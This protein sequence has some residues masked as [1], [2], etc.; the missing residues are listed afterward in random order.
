MKG[1]INPFS[2]DKQY[3]TD[4][5]LCF[6]LSKIEEAYSQDLYNRNQYSLI[7]LCIF[8]IL[9]LIFSYFSNSC[10]VSASECTHQSLLILN[11]LTIF[12]T[13]FLILR[14]KSLTPWIFL[15]N[16]L[17]P[18]MKIMEEF[19][20][21]VPFILI[22]GH[23]TILAYFLIYSWRK[24]LI[25]EFSGYFMIYIYLRFHDYFLIEVLFK[26]LGFIS[27]TILIS[28]FLLF[29]NEKVSK[30]KWVLYD[31]FKKSERLLEFLIDE[32]NFPI[33]LVDSRN[34]IILQ[35]FQALNLLQQTNANSIKLKKSIGKMKIIGQNR[36]FLELFP[37]EN[38]QNSIVANTILNSVL[39]GGKAYS[40]GLL[41]LNL[42]K[43]GQNGDIELENGEQSNQ[44]IA[45][46]F[47]FEM[48][49]Q[50]F[51]WKGLKC[52]LIGLK[53]EKNLQINH[54]FNDFMIN[55]SLQTLMNLITSHSLEEQS[56]YDS[57]LQNTALME[58]NKLLYNRLYNCHGFLFFALLMKN[59]LLN[60]FEKLTLEPE[61]QFY[62]TFQ[63]AELFN[64]ILHILKRK[65]DKYEV[66]LEIQNPQIDRNSLKLEK[67]FSNF[68][69]IGNDS[70]MEKQS[71]NDK[72]P[73][74]GNNSPDLEKIAS[75][76]G[77]CHMLQHII[78]ILIKA[79]MKIKL[80]KRFTLSYKLEK[81]ENPLN[82]SEIEPFDHNPPG[83]NEKK[84]ED[85][86]F[87]RI[88]IG[89]EEFSENKPGIPNNYMILA[90]FL[91]STFKE[92]K[93]VKEFL[94]EIM[95]Y[96]KNFIKSDQDSSFLYF[97][98]KNP[99]NL[100]LFF[101]PYML[102]ALDAQFKI[103]HDEDINKNSTKFIFLSM[104]KI[105]NEE[106]MLPN[107]KSG[108]YFMGTGEEKEKKEEIPKPMIKK[109][110]LMIIK[111]VFAFEF[112]NNKKPENEPGFKKVE[113]KKEES[114]DEINFL[115]RSYSKDYQL[116]ED[117]PIQK[118]SSN[119]TQ[120][121][122][123]KN[124][125]Q[126]APSISLPSEQFSKHL[127]SNKLLPVYL[128]H[129][130]I[131]INYFSKVA[132]RKPPSKN[133]PPPL[134]NIKKSEI[135]IEEELKK[136]LYHMQNG[137]TATVEHILN[138]IINEENNKGASIV[139]PP[140]NYLF[141]EKELSSRNLINN[142]N[143]NHN[144]NENNHAIILKPPYRKKLTIDEKDDVSSFIFTES[145]KTESLM[146][147]KSND[148][149][150]VND[151]SDPNT[152]CNELKENPKTQSNQLRP[153][154]ILRNDMNNPHVF[155]SPNLLRSKVEEKHV[156]VRGESLIKYLK[157]SS[158]GQQQHKEY[159]KMKEKK[160]DL[161]GLREKT[162]KNVSPCRGS[163]VFK[164]KAKRDIRKLTYTR[165]WCVL[166]IKGQ[167][168]I[169]T[170]INC[171]VFID[172]FDPEPPSFEGFSKND[173]EKKIFIRKL[174]KK[175]KS[176]SDNPSEYK[177]KQLMPK[178]KALVLNNI[179]ELVKMDR[180]HKFEEN[181]R[182]DD[183]PMKKSKHGYLEILKNLNYKEKP[184]ILAY[185]SESQINDPGKCKGVKSLALKVGHD[186]K[187][188][189]CCS[190]P[191][192]IKT[193]KSFILKSFVYHVIIIE[194]EMKQMAGWKSV[195]KI[196]NF[197]NKYKPKHRS[198]ICGLLNDDERDYEI[199]VKW[200]FDEFLRKPFDSNLFE[201]IIK[202][203]MAQ[204]KAEE[205]KEIKEN[206]KS[207]EKKPIVSSEFDWLREIV[208]T[209]AGEAKE[210]MYQKEPILMMTID[211]NDFILMGMSNLKLKVSFFIVTYF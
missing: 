114:K 7:L 59:F 181:K 185:D 26:N 97:L 200:G 92:Q 178:N 112:F 138:E 64:T 202:R 53:D 61:N 118:I 176:I 49:C 109:R 31:S 204:I 103:I 206:E 28:V 194:L 35:N 3:Q 42:Y 30:E 190:G 33:F 124:P 20:S 106:S 66:S 168:R 74:K 37:Q 108:G 18:Y 122:P 32:L 155:R 158:I 165:R 160:L 156:L 11:M 193:F 113:E 46:E 132:K 47:L 45:E 162:E 154:T 10:N 84:D 104:V 69:G 2:G 54:L 189:L 151:S 68:S 167:T 58:N 83:L 12:L 126:L 55:K 175:T 153:R 211:D 87:F 115:K 8:S 172:K 101:L 166:K 159:T 123:L 81:P 22:T 148:D 95:K 144:N 120:Q 188:D 90:D 21:R 67:N 4:R 16:G 75:L 152:G 171:A 80:C 51:I 196:R 38:S 134:L 5:T 82:L 73:N 19:D 77:P 72:N 52:A 50:G 179:K 173:F 14:R 177:G 57:L 130:F 198:F 195:K 139:F 110:T 91:S 41:R 143:N 199:Y 191:E 25:F 192:L 79:V 27:L 39:S 119:P 117:L 40:C 36:N 121:N 111:K 17:Y 150:M 63:P 56:Y 174:T 102:K 9:L 98:N 89:F 128:F 88:E 70:S 147:G 180:L 99:Q 161:K 136:Y 65:T 127:E 203:K 131:S 85:L 137:F 146:T 100:G 86:M 34:H 207:E 163:D 44:I 107:K 149:E 205:K 29:L 133:H 170:E 135:Y 186:Y 48:A 62:Q 145:N 43:D 116:N 182:E 183:P 157:T 93:K 209:V 105:K 197:E 94:T 71:S 141:Q 169:A 208:K 76:Y 13:I 201:E 187:F 78:I 60:N 15:I 6:K 142:N 125:I 1:N 164:R 210:A 184:T 140:K 96:D 23:L 24:V 129:K